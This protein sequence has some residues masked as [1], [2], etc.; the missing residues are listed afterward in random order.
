M[1]VNL[2]DLFAAERTAYES[3]VTVLLCYKKENTDLL[4]VGNPFY[5]SICKNAL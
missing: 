4:K 1:S 3:N 2:F 5:V